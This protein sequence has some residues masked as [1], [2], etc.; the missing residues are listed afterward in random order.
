MSKKKYIDY[1]DRIKIELLHNIEKNKPAQIAE[2]LGYSERTIYRELLRGYCDNLDT[3]LRKI[4]VYSAQLAQRDYDEKAAAKG[5]NLKIGNDHALAA[6]IEEKMVKEK[7]SPEA[8]LLEI[9]TKGLQFS[10][11]ISKT[12]LYRY[13]DDDLFLNISNKDLPSGKREKQKRKKVRRISYKDPMKESI[14]K[15]PEEIDTREEFGH[16]EMDTVEGPAKGKSTCLLVLTERK[17]RDEFAVKLPTRTAAEV[18]KAMDRLE[19]KF[20]RQTPGSFSQIFKSFT[21]DNGSEF[22]DWRGIEKSWYKH[23]GQRTKV[24][25]CHPF[26][27]F[28]RGSNENCNKL[29]RRFIPKGTPI[30]N[31]SD[32]EIQRIIYWINHYPRK[33]HGGYSS[34]DLFEIELEK[35]IAA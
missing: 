35:I 1:D 13:I 15:R 6:Y 22:A 33:L 18:V 30:S 2:K 14:D 31:Y 17:T 5:V 28:E 24:Y 3:H 19:R 20:E 12:T 4:R 23:G 29:I 8:V 34:N 21:L 32:E 11:T 27:S 9:K 10:V 25:F 26:S 7:Y 16:W